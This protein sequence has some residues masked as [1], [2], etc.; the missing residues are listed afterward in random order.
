M[1]GHLEMLTLILFCSADC[2]INL[3]NFRGLKSIDLLN[4][5]HA[6]SLPKL[7]SIAFVLVLG[8]ISISA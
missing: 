6:F 3:A 5:G 7:L 4:Y 1:S 2:E 8:N